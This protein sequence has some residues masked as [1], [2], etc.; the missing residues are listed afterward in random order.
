MTRKLTFD[1]ISKYY[2]KCNCK[3][4]EVEY[5]G[6]KVHTKYICKCGNESKIRFDSFQERCKKC[7]SKTTK[8]T[9]DFVSEYFKKHNCELLETEY[10]NANTKM[11]YKCKC[12]N[13]SSITYGNFQSGKRCMKCGGCEVLKYD[14]VRNYFKEQECEL[15]EIEYINNET[16]MSYRCKCGNESSITFGSFQSGSRCS[17]CGGSEVLKY[18]FVKNY[19]KEQDC[20]LLETEYTNAN[21]KMK[22]IC[23]CGNESSIRFC[24]FQN[25]HRCNK[26]KNKTERIVADFFQEEYTNIIYQA[27]FDW[28][29]GKR[30]LSFDF[31]LDDLRTIIE[32][33]GK[34]HFEQVSN[35]K[36]PE[37][38]QKSDIYKM[39]CALEHEY[40]IIRICQNDVLHNTIDWKHLLK[41]AIN[42]KTNPVIYI[43]K[44]LNLY[45][46]YK[47]KQ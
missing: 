33:D 21:T 38:T 29:K 24:T 5:K 18:D 7:P 9:F 39:K 25:G 27:K 8:L 20:E 31:L 42:D 15:L 3:L 11:K 34:Q 4:L 46:D 10:I 23:K 13:E 40:K 16:K 36:S 6:N 28:C 14:F 1:Y 41:S 26:C 32:V 2:K 43:S 12:G 47:I 35:W 37:E 44:N 19:F 45:D 17:K 22:Y 30:K